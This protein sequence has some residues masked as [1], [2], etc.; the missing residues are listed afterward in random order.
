MTVD[1]NNIIAAE[2]TLREATVDDEPFLFRVYADSRR[3]EL[4]HVPWTDEQRHAF[5]A[6]QFAA[7][8]RYYRENYDG[9]TYQ[10][11]LADG[12]PVGRLFVARWPDEI[13]VVDIALLTEYRGAGVGTRVMRELCD[14]AD[15]IGTPI[16][17]HVEK[18]NAARRLYTRLGFGE[19]QD[20]GVY[21]YLVRPPRRVS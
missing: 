3:E 18:Q 1:G 5:L 11:V 6:S 2:L 19:R 7:Q 17:I 13:R 14:E 12:Q 4:A 15:A 21:S 16:G 8:Y 10:I 20:R 9:A